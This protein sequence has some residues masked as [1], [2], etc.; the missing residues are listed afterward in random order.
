MLVGYLHGLAVIDADLME[1]NGDYQKLALK[2]PVDMAEGD[3]REPLLNLLWF[4]FLFFI[5]LTW[6][7]SWSNITLF[8]ILTLTPLL[9]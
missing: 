3:R 9:T 2:K 6:S 1:Q 8:F 7:R 4:F 5:R